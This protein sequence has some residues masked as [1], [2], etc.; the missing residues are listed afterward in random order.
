MAR[1]GRTLSG[2]ITWRDR[3]SL[4]RRWANYAY[5]CAVDAGG[6][7]TSRAL[8]HAENRGRRKTG[9]TM[10]MSPLRPRLCK[11]QIK[12]L[13]IQKD[14]FDRRGWCDRQ[15]AG[16]RRREHCLHRVR[17][18]WPEVASKLQPL[19]RPNQGGFLVSGVARSAS[20]S[21]G[22]TGQRSGH[23]VLRDRLRPTR[24]ADGRV[25]R[26]EVWTLERVI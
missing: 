17:Y 13:C 20:R 8:C 16:R 9:R 4:E 18:A 24:R 2:F 21:T 5:V 12:A 6:R 7:R 1:L 25:S 10:L 15:L 22:N 26:Q 23:F 19:G 3:S 11:Q 14:W